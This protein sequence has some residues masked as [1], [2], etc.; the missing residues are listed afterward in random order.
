MVCAYTAALLLI[1]AIRFANGADTG[2]AALAPYAT[3]LYVAAVVLA[4]NLLP[5]AGL[6]FDR[7]GFSNLQ[8][9]HLL[10]G[11]VGLAAIQ[12]LAWVLGPLWESL[13]SDGRD[14]SRFEDIGGSPAE[15]IKLLALSW[16]FATFGEELAFR[17]LLLQG[18]VAVLGK[19]RGKL[20]SAV[21]LQAAVFA[22][23]H[24]YQGPVGMVETF[25]SGLVYG[26]ITVLGGFAIW[27]AALAH[28]A[29]NTVG[30]LRLY[31]VS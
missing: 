23:T 6:Q 18:L 20:V 2:L 4:L 22:A 11:L 12:V 13:F 31:F 1:A 16:T 10:L 17:I 25:L 27:P 3:W 30:L 8:W 5:R 21:I 26:A 29:G 15:L 9:Q 19:G 7:F 24:A 28:G 14:L